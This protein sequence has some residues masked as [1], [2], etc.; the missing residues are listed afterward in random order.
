VESYI[1]A[2]FLKKMSFHGL[3]CLCQ[4]QAALPSLSSLHLGGG[5]LARHVVTKASPTFSPTTP[6]KRSVN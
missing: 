4:A 6:E 3:V 2:E 1:T 5:D